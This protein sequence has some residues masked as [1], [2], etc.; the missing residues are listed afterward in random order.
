MTKAT[1]SVNEFYAPIMQR[2]T[3]PAQRLLMELLS[4]KIDQSAPKL[5]A[6]IEAQAK[7]E[8]PNEEDESP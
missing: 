8:Q 2:Y 6:A 7:Q 3:Q 1:P 4:K 5:V